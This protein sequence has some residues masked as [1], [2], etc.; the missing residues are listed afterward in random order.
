MATK[1]R[2]TGGKKRRK[3]VKRKSTAR[4]VVV[5]NGVRRKRSTKRKSIT[6]MKTGGIVSSLK[7][8]AF[9]Y[10]GSTLGKVAAAQINVDNNIKAAGLILLGAVGHRIQPDL[11][12]GVISQGLSLIVD[13]M[14]Q[15]QGLIQGNINALPEDVVESIEDAAMQG[16][17]DSNIGEVDDEETITGYSD[18]DSLD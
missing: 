18:P 5:I 9:V 12:T 8:G 7:K 4:R 14:L 6:G 15:K 1:K 10:A 13:P 17:Y 11:M 3:A 2:R 16:A